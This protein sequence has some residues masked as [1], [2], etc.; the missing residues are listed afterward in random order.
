VN[1]DDLGTIKAE[2]M[3]NKVKGKTTES[4]SVGNHNLY[5]V[6]EILVSLDTKRKIK[7]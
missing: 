4:V 2:D 1:H 7:R 3:L 6:Q 5:R